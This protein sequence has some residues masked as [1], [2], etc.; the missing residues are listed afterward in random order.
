M[1][2]EIRARRSTTITNVRLHPSGALELRFVKP[3]MK[4][5]AGQ[6]LFLNCPEVSKFQ[7]HPF[8][9]SS[10]PED[11]FI[12]VHV[13]QIG[14]FTKALGARLGAREGTAKM[15]MTPGEK[16]EL[17]DEKGGYGRRGDF[18]EISPGM[19]LSLP[20]LRIDG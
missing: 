15:M 13:R 5:K 18:I 11:P 12:S 4:Y 7:W 1:Y 2:R 20:Q 8:T 19:G 16:Y 10:A 17:D 9:I 3:S 6:W 14:D